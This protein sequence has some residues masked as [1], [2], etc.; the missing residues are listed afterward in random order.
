MPW[1]QTG[2]LYYHVQLEHP[3]K[4]REITG[5]VVGAI[6]RINLSSIENMG[7]GIRWANI[8]FSERTIFTNKSFVITVKTYKNK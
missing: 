8:D 7:M 1:P 5:L 3:D 2:S 4:G 6:A